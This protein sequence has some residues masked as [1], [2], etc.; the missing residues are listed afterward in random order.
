MQQ[1]AC[2][3][4]QKICHVSPFLSHQNLNSSR[5]SSKAHKG[6]HNWVF[7]SPGQFRRQGCYTSQRKRKCV[8]KILSDA[9]SRKFGNILYLPVSIC[10]LVM[11]LI[12]PMY[13]FIICHYNFFSSIVTGFCLVKSHKYFAVFCVWYY[14]GVTKGL[15]LQKCHDD[16]IKRRQFPRVSGPL[17]PVNSPHKGPLTRSFDIFLIGA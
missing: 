15:G 7:V 3:K 1:K 17:S 5:L 6:N 2:S 13:H 10:M 14:I 4:R 8:R 9:V 16:V 12:M 11:W